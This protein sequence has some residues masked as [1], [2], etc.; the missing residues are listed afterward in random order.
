VTGIF[1]L[2]AGM[3]STVS[4]CGFTALDFFMT[5]VNYSGLMV[6]AVDG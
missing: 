2:C 6:A 5:A 4:V 3:H 1:S